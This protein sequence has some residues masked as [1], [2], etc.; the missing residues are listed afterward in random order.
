[1]SITHPIAP[2]PPPQDERHGEAEAGQPLAATSSPTGR[3]QVEMIERA[4]VMF[5]GNGAHPIASGRPGDG[6]PATIGLCMQV[7]A[8]VS[9]LFATRAREVCASGE[10]PDLKLSKEE[11]YGHLVVDV[12]RGNA[13]L[14]A[15]EPRQIGKRL[16]VY[17]ARE[18]KAASR[19]KD[20]ARH[21]IRKRQRISAAG[22]GEAAHGG[23]SLE[24]AIDA[25]QAE[26]YAREVDLQLPNLSTTVVCSIRPSRRERRD[27][28]VQRAERERS[29]KWR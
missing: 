14:L 10:R 7:K 15:N 18:A 21:E 17:A 4:E 28:R 3:E 26:R 2:F 20:E 8:I 24:E 9:N 27:V 16:D 1:M 22:G 13:T 12:L 23:L 25:A 11:A 29:K 6:K 19:A 5:F